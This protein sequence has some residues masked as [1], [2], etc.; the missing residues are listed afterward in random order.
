MYLKGKVVDDIVMEYQPKEVLVVGCHVG[1]VL[2]QILKSLPGNARI[3]V[4]ESDDEF[5]TFSKLL[6]KLVGQDDKVNIA[7]TT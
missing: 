4:V 1:Y 6:L 2:L 7:A 3:F 5:S